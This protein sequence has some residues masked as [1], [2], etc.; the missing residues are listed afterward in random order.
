MKNMMLQYPNVV[1]KTVG[2][3]ASIKYGKA[4]GVATGTWWE[5]GVKTNGNFQIA[6]EDDIDKGGILLKSNGG[7][8]IGKKFMQPSDDVP[9]V[10]AAKATAAA[11]NI[12]VVETPD[13]NVT[14]LNNGNFNV[15]SPLNVFSERGITVIK[16][17][18]TQGIQLQ[19]NGITSFGKNGNQDFNITLAQTNSFQVGTGNVN[20]NGNLI[21]RSDL[22]QGIGLQSN[23]NIIATGTNANQDIN[24]IPKGTG[25][26]NVNG[27]LSINNGGV[28]NGPNWRLDK[29][30]DWVRLRNRN[31]GYHINFAANNLYAHGDLFHKGTNMQDLLNLRA[32]VKIHG[33]YNNLPNGG[34]Q[35]IDFPREGS[36]GYF[37]AIC[38]ETGKITIITYSGG[39]NYSTIAGRFNQSGFD[40]AE[41]TGERTKIWHHWM[42]GQTAYVIAHWFD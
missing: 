21:V 20:V 14:P 12:P 36:K 9:A 32:R 16:N 11:A 18:F 8:D 2:G 37:I 27:N 17:D 1:P 33:P 38:V 31:D 42:G 15:S 5:T 41:N 22:K 13:I 10:A 23:N 30:D 7:I 26:F 29:P 35:A 4:G 34:S 40:F 24:V 3:D 39:N 25:S 28:L 19:N 6:R